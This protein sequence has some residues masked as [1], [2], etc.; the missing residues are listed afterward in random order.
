MY[1]LYFLAP[2][3]R[4]HFSQRAVQK[5]HPNCLFKVNGN[6]RKMKIKISHTVLPSALNFCSPY[7]AGIWTLRNSWNCCCK[8]LVPTLESFV[9]F[10]RFSGI[11]S[12]TLSRNVKPL[13]TSRSWTFERRKQV[14]LLPSLLNKL[15]FNFGLSWTETEQWLFFVKVNNL[16]CPA[17]K[18]ILS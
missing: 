10:F 12:H 17:K 7:T 9:A 3:R 8:C 5:S 16:T 18:L 1:S 4:L 11:N 6:R 13:F 15:S 2:L 14:Q